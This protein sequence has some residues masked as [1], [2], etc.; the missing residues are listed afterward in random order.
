[1]VPENDNPVRVLVP[2][3]EFNLIVTALADR[4][5]ATAL[6]VKR[7]GVEKDQLHFGEQIPSALKERLLDK[8]FVAAN[9][10]DGFGELLDCVS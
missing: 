7:S 10:P 3:L 8:V 2:L 4:L 1:M 6:E 5:S 9:R